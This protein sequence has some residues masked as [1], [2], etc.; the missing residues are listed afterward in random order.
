[1]TTIAVD[2]MGGDYAPDE[3]VHGAVIA[4]K[5]YG[6]KIYLCGL[7]DVIQR[8][9]NKYSGAELPIEI[10]PASEVIDMGE[11]QPASAVRKRPN[12]SIVVAMNQV[13]NGLAGGVVAAGSTGAA[14][15]A[16]LFTLKRIEGIERPCIAAVMPTHDK[17]VILADAGANVDSASKHL[18]QNALMGAA[19]SKG[20]FKI[21][22]PKVALLNIGE[23]PG[24]GNVIVKE[25][26]DIL[27][28]IHELNFVG[29]VEGR[30]V[31]QGACDVCVCDGFV[32]NVF[33]K[34]AEGVAKMVAT[35]LREELTRDVMG[36][37]GALLAKNSFYRLKKRIDYAEYGGAHLLGV[38]GVCIIAHGSSKHI[39]I[40]NAIKV[41]KS[42]VE[43]DIIKLIETSVQNYVK[44]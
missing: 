28:S 31:P 19:L 8:E 2:A 43:G 38:K 26:Y 27:K 23:E 29:N 41:A 39:A 17:P 4:A 7:E 5:E 12:S 24:K 44:N 34:T 42:A 21:N 18:V 1:M 32:G 22:N 25:A 3:I 6:V 13:A 15:A 37:L 35:M 33:L 10:I 20:L 11:C 40:K 36:K 16:A 30:D 9:L 14:A